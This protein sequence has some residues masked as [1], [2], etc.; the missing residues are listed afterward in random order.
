MRLLGKRVTSSRLNCQTE[1]SV[2][3]VSD[4]GASTGGSQVNGEEI[5]F[6]IHFNSFD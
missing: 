2:F 4:D 5:A 6:I 3:N 1:L